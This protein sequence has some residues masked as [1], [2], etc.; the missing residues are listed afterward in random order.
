MTMQ[1]KGETL[2]D[3]RDVMERVRD[4]GNAVLL[5][6]RSGIVLRCKAVPPIYMQRVAEKFVLPPPPQVRIDRGDD[7]YFEENVD[8]PRW[9]REC[10]EINARAART[11]QN[12]M[13][14]IG[15]EAV[16]VPSGKYMPEEDGWIAEVRRADKLIG[17]DTPL[18]LDEPDL[19]YLSWLNFYALDNSSDVQL[20][21]ML[22]SFLAG[23]SEVETADAVASF[24]NIRERRADHDGAAPDA[25]NNGNRSEDVDPGPDLGV[26]P[27]RSRTVRAP[28]LAAVPSAKPD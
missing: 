26:R 28:K 25:D 6:L 11:L 15:T 19:R 14:G 17:V 4:D 24:R 22:P 1:E 8:D 7:S 10:G 23:P 20:A 9:K 13:L 27:T 3:V 12:L 18:D 21:G 5:T 16:E 2:A